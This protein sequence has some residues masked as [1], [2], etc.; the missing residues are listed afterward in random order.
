M[1]KILFINEGSASPFNPNN[2]SVSHYVNPIIFNKYK[3]KDWIEVQSSRFRSK[4]RMKEFLLEHNKSNNQLIMVTKSYGCVETYRL[5]LNDFNLYFGLYNQIKWFNIDAFSVLGY[6]LKRDHFQWQPNWASIV[7]AYNF[8]QSNDRIKGAMFMGA[9][10]YH[11][12]STHM[13]II[14]HPTVLRT[15]KDMC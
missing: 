15:I 12:S 14:N 7:N 13:D 2:K 3:I 11:L 9:T 4:K 6:N 1:S 5:M 10:D 8:R